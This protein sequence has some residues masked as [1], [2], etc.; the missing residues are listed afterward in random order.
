MGL[1]DIVPLWLH[2]TSALFS[3]IS[4]AQHRPGGGR[5]CC[6]WLA[7]CFVPGNGRLVL[8]PALWPATTRRT[9]HP[10]PET[11]ILFCVCG[12]IGSLLLHAHGLSLAEA[13]RGSSLVAVHR[14]LIAVAALV[15]EHVLSSCGAG[16][17][18]FEACGIFPDQGSNPGPLHL[19]ADS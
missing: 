15:S 4:S 5:R 2:V 8:L 1:C 12:H 19:Q 18:C 6:F 13:D 7:I 17:R 10:S 11:S 3:S 16:L 9:A 14:L